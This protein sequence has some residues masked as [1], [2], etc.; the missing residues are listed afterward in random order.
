VEDY[1]RPNVAG[2][3]FERY[4]Q[5]IQ[6]HLK[7]A[8]GHHLLAQLQPLHIQT[9]YSAALQNGRRDGRP[10]GLSAL[11]FLH[12]HRILREALQHAVRCSCGREIPRMRW[13]RH[14]RG[15]RRC[16]RW[17][18]NKPRIS[19]RWQSARRNRHHHGPIPDP[20]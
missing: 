11:T 8:L 18:R 16:G 3:T 15:A 7:P 20:S 13:S 14:G 17:M 12:H 1:A 2:K 5:V 19:W 6:L 4:E 9:C 10:G